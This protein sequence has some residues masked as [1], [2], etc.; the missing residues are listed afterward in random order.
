MR[1]AEGRTNTATYT[2]IVRILRP[3]VKALTER[4]WSGIENLPQQGGFIAVSNH[5]SNFDPLTF[6]HFMVDNDIPVKFLGK[7]ELFDAPVVG[8][9]LKGARQIPVYRGT[10]RAAESLKDAERAIAAGECV[11]VFP[12]GTLTH[13][14]EMWPMQARTGVARLA[15]ATKAPVIPVAQ[16]GAHR[17]IPHFEAKP[18]SLRKQRVDVRAM[19]AVDLSAYYDRPLTSELLR[20][21]TDAIMWD[22]TRGVAEIRGETPPERFW[23]RRVD[24]DTRAAYKERKAAEKAARRGSKRASARRDMAEGEPS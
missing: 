3:L 24:G 5:V 4:H 18:S 19:P 17:I 9:F 8:W 2:T 23:D 7:A 11:G 16:W 15:L 10:V 20:E 13:D 12:E 1:A 14:P 6:G 21:V 22:L